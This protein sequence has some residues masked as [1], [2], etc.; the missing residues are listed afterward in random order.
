[1][2]MEFYRAFFGGVRIWIN[3][4]HA[5]VAIAEEESQRHG[6]AAMDALHLAAAFLGEAQVLYTLEREEKP[7][8]RT[9]LVR[10]EC[11]AAR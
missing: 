5:M 10:V 6:I 11:V 2:E 9:A 8:H 1:M 4:L 7:I 3:D